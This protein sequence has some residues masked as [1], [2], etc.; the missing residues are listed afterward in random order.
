MQAQVSSSVG[1]VYF[2][3]AIGECGV[4]WGEHGLVGVQLPEA[5]PGAVRSRLKRRFPSGAE[6]VP[7]PDVQTA[8]DGIVALLAGEPRDLSDI[9]LDMEQV[10]DFNRR[11]YEVA[12]TIPPGATLSYGDIAARLGDP[13]SARAVGQALGRNPFVIVVPC[14]RVLA[15]GG[16][17]GGFSAN[18]GTATKLTLLAIEGAQLF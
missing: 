13:G 2:E 10:P 4:A 7:P 12:R 14:H 9:P 18:G 16:K 8:I 11:V 3:T 6:T 1:V 17:T 15:A 5:R